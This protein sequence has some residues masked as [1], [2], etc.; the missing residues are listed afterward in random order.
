[1]LLTQGYTFIKH[2]N[3][4]I[5]KFILKKRKDQIAKIYPCLNL[6]TNL[7]RQHK[8]QKGYNYRYL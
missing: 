5:D 1:M 3:K 7:I 6:F 8:I 2:N 4:I